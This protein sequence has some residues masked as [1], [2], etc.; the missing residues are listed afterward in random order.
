MVFPLPEYELTT[1]TPD[2]TRIQLETA[3]AASGEKQT[4]PKLRL[5]TFFLTVHY[6]AGPNPLSILGPNRGPWAV[7]TTVAKRRYGYTA[8]LWFD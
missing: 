6:T 2:F 3:W 7:A 4:Q 1:Q 5:L 8:G